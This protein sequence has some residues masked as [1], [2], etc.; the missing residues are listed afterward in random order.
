MAE[1]LSDTRK[2]QIELATIQ[3]FKDS[4]EYLDELTKYGNMAYI[5]Y[6]EDM[7]KQMI[8]RGLR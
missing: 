8:E 3:H 1:E 6:M 2:L 7:I 4:V 5:E